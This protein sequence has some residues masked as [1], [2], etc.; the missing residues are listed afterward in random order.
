M[1][2]PLSDL[3]V[4]DVSTLFAG[5]MAARMFADYGATVTK[6][7]HPKGDPLRNFGPA[8]KAGDSYAWKVINRNKRCVI[9][10]LHTPNG[11]ATLQDLVRNADILIEN[12]RP[13]VLDSWGIGYKNLKRINPDLVMVSVTGFGQD[14]PYADHPGFG[15]VA[16]AMSGVAMMA[17]LTG[18]P[19]QLPPFPLGDTLTALHAALGALI[20]LY[21][22][23][24]LGFGQHVDVNIWESILSSTGAQITTYAATGHE[25][26]RHGNQSPNN[27]PR[28]VYRCGDGLWVA[29]S[30]PSDDVARRV[31]QLVGRGDLTKQPWFTHG[32]SRADHREEV[33][34][35]I[36]DWV[37]VRDRDEVLRKFTT[38]RAAVG[39]V[40]TIAEIVKDPHLA[41]R[42]FLTTVPDQDV[43]SVLMTG[44]PMRFSHTKGR[45]SFPGQSY[46]TVSQKY[47]KYVSQRGAT[48]Q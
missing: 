11:V 15:T 20:A 41:A 4:L 21:D 43:G 13:G 5:P 40:Y 32:K 36:E 31:F 7:E 29:I 1:S 47:P 48:D 8:P 23:K 33:D 46:R 38:A 24:H 25:P 6:L 19:P 35:A 22:R 16:E 26:S 27:A 28:N 10:D 45:I 30:A 2:G 9:A 14:G 12:F 17:G 44:V 39:P 42:N 3:T 18:E 34:R 37:G